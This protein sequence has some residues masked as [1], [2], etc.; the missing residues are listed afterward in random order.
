MFRHK[1]TEKDQCKGFPELPQSFAALQM[2][3]PEQR[4]DIHGCVR[5]DQARK[6]GCGICCRWRHV[7]RFFL[8]SN[9]SFQ[10]HSAESSFHSGRMDRNTCG[11]KLPS[12]ALCDQYSELVP[13]DTAFLKPAASPDSRVVRNGALLHPSTR[14]HLENERS[15]S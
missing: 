5:K 11:R 7:V 2:S 8:I 9:T 1:D 6:H 4:R 12:A 10:T 15:A 13:M 3:L 14:G